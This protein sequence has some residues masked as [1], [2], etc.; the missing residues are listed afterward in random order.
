MTRPIPRRDRGLGIAVSAVMLGACALNTG[1]VVL[2]PERD[3]HNAAVA[4]R[5]G[6]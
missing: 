6:D 2:L 4:V 5:Q 1:T 3:G